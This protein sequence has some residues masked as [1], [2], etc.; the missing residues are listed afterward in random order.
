MLQ[1]LVHRARAAA[2]DVA[3][4]LAGFTLDHP[5][6]HFGFALGEAEGGDQGFDGGGV[7]FFAQDDQPFVVAGLVMEGSEQAAS[8]MVL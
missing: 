1:V 7:V 3:D 6:E 4:V 5:V 8:S 2:E